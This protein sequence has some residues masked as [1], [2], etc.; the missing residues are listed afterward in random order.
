[1]DLSSEK[2]IKFK[3]EEIKLRK[4]Y[5]IN[6]SFGDYHIYQWFLKCKKYIEEGLLDEFAGHKAAIEIFKV[7]Y[8]KGY[9]AV[10]EANIIKNSRTDEDTI[11]FLLKQI[12]N[13]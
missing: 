12:G 7:G 13:K 9:K 8:G 6:S 3:N 4:R 2:I 1:M 11:M 10:T 5:Q